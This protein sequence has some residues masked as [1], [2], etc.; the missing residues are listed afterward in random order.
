MVVPESKE[1][2]PAK[3]LDIQMLMFT[4][5]KERTAKEYAELLDKAGFHMTNVIPTHSPMQIIEAVKK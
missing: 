5:G 2:H 1:P 3:T 4:G